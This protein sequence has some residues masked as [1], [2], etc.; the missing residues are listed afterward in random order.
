MSTG[1]LRNKVAVTT[2]T[3]YLVLPYKKKKVLPYKVYTLGVASPTYPTRQEF[4]IMW[5][6]RPEIKECNNMLVPQ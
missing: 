2:K 4:S 6:I 3:Q 5:I 1:A